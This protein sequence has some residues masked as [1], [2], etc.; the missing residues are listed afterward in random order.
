LPCPPGLGRWLGPLS[1]GTV[2][3]IFE[4]ARIGLPDG[5]VFAFERVPD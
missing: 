2:E 4:A 1:A 3:Q 5:L